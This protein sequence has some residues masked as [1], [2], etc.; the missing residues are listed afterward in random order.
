MKKVLTVFLSIALVLAMIP[1]MAFATD[2]G[3]LYCFY[4]DDVNVNSSNSEITAKEGKTLADVAMTSPQVEIDRQGEFYFAT[5]SGD[6]YTA[7]D[8]NSLQCSNKN[9]TFSQGG[10]NWECDITINAVGENYTITYTDGS[11]KEYNLTMMCGLPDEGCYSS[12]TASQ[13]SYL[14]YC[15]Q[16]STDETEFYVV[17]KLTDEIS[18][19]KYVTDFDENKSMEQMTAVSGVTLAKMTDDKKVWKATVNNTAFENTQK[20][21]GQIVIEYKDSD[22]GNENTTYINSFGFEIYG[23]EYNSDED[24]D[25]TS[26]IEFYSDAACET[27]IW[28]FSVNTSLDPSANCFYIKST[29]GEPSISTITTYYV[30]KE[31]ESQKSE[32]STIYYA[33]VYNCKESDPTEKYY[34]YTDDKQGNKTLETNEYTRNSNTDFD[35]PTAYVSQPVAVGGETNVYKVSFKANEDNEYRGHE[36]MDFEITAG[37]ETKTLEIDYGVNLSYDENAYSALIP[38]HEYFSH[39][40][41]PE[42]DEPWIGVNNNKPYWNGLGGASSSDSDRCGSELW[43]SMDTAD[44]YRITDIKNAADNES[45]PYTITAEYYYNVYNG[46]GIKIEFDEQSEYGSCVSSGENKAFYASQSVGS[47]HYTNQG[48]FEV[49]N[50]SVTEFKKFCSEKNYTAKLV[51]YALSYT[52]YIPVDEKCEVKIETEQVSNVN[53]VKALQSGTTLTS[54]SVDAT[55]DMQ[56]NLENYYG[57]DKEIIDVYE[58]SAG[59]SGTLNSTVDVVIPVSGDSTDYEIVWFNDNTPV[60]TVTRYTNGAVMFT[61]GHFS[62]YAIVKDKSSTSGGVVVTPAKEDDV[63]ITTDGNISTTVKDVK[64][65]T[66]KNESGQDVTKTTASVSDTLAN[67]LIDSAVSNKSSKVEITVE[68]SGNNV[69]GEIQTELVISKE[70]VKTIAKETNVSLVITTDNSQVELDN[71]ALETIAAETAGDTVRIVVNGNTGLKEE[72][73][74]A[75]DAIGENGEVFDIQAV[76][77]NKTIHNFNGGKVNV[78]LPVPEK[79]KGEEIAVVYINDK[80]ICEILNHTLEAVGANSFIRFET[81]HFSN[82][83]IVKKTD[84]DKQIKAQEENIKALIKDVKL[85]ATTSRTSKKNVKVKALGIG[86][87]NSL[88]KEIESMGY[89][90]K[91]RFYRST[92]KSSGYAS[93]TE[94]VTNT[95]INTAGKKGTKYYYKAKL[96]IYSGDDL[97]ASTK[98]AQCKYGFRTWSKNHG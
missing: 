71:K 86:D 62:K 54:T 64:T 25:S 95:Y 13:E 9:V 47:N 5:L 81:T 28:N 70:A 43:L 30:G 33:G 82:F 66:V 77:G 21:E 7:V 1:G 31:D 67:E 51:G 79:L 65:E 26:G 8:Y 76:V 23:P 56:A 87:A 91:Y 75:A 61:T 24:E 90:V 12:E 94:K 74:S 45:L 88:I 27:E 49:G 89:T 80:G 73:K 42:K 20:L 69:S 34:E 17:S 3:Q 55:T 52:I 78:V 36:N 48:S 41:E 68:N 11:D 83:A 46:N 50:E 72:Q 39:F 96:C 15:F 40:L 18:E 32:N 57:E 16:Y 22:V 63:K 58:L 2:K 60:P 14:N 85:K 53:E 59:D 38:T 98:F 35:A 29:V 37:Y 10:D 19:V 84:A 4:T 92:K 6:K 44:G 93:K 97:V